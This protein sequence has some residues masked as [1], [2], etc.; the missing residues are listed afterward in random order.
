[1]FGEGGCVVEGLE[2]VVVVVEVVAVEVVAV[3]VVAD[4][5]A[6]GKT[7]GDFGGSVVDI[8]EG[9]TGVAFVAGGLVLVELG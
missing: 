1:M 9:S 2:G 3:E 4:N 7:A 6:V 5:M 8:V